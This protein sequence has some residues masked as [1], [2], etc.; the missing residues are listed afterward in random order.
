[1]SVYANSG[2]ECKHEWYM[3]GEK[4]HELDL[5]R[6][7]YCDTAKAEGGKYKVIL[8]NFPTLSLKEIVDRVGNVVRAF[9]E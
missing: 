1:M 8:P 3:V 7:F 2:A 9:R 6:C 5:Y 4:V